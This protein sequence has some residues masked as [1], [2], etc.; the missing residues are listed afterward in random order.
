MQNAT[1]DKQQIVKNIE[2]SL[3]NATILAIVFR[4]IDNSHKYPQL[5]TCDSLSGSEFNFTGVLPTDFFGL[6]YKI[7]LREILGCATYEVTS[8]EYTK[9]V[10]DYLKKVR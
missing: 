2:Y 8:I 6:K 1:S 9:I 3:K 10:G 4:D 5:V 7:D